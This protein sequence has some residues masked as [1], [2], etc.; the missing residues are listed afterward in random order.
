MSAIEAKTLV[1]VTATLTRPANTTA[2][3]AGDAMD[4]TAG[5]GLTFAGAARGTGGGGTIEDAVFFSNDAVATGPDVELWLFSAALAAYD[6][7]NAAFTPV[8]ADYYTSSGGVTDGFVGVIQFETGNAFIGTAGAGGNQ[9]IP[10][11]RTFLPL[12]FVC[13]T[14]ATSLFGVL[15]ARNAYVPV[16]AEVFRVWLRIDQS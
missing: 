13:A 5:A 11:T 4:T 14:N 12:K 3:A 7:D 8:D 9:I 16:S 1:E 6:A 15:V 10:A 2:Y